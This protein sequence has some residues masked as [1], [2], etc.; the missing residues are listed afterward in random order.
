M[1][2]LFINDLLDKIDNCE[3]SYK[4]NSIICACPTS[5]DDMVILENTKNSLQKLIDTCYTNSTTERY[6][7][8]AQKCKVVVF[9]E[10]IDN[11]RLVLNIAQVYPAR[12]RKSKI[13]RLT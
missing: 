10:H 11:T 9:S 1:Y 7:Y 4:I 5:A 6:L 2:I 8:N 12:L 3:A 13:T